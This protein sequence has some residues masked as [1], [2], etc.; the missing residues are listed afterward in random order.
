[1]CLLGSL[2][3]KKTK[4]QKI[5]ELGEDGAAAGGTNKPQT[6]K[7]APLKKGKSKAK[8]AVPPANKV[9]P[10][11]STQALDVTKS[12]QSDIST[13]TNDSNNN[14]N[15]PKIQELQKTAEI[16]KKAA[17]EMIDPSDLI[18]TQQISVNTAEKAMAGLSKVLHWLNNLCQMLLHD[19]GIKWRTIVDYRKWLAK[20]IQAQMNV[21]FDSLFFFEQKTEG[22]REREKKKTQSV[23]SVS[24]IFFVAFL[25]KN[26]HL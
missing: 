9:P 17:I 14:K 10:V 3:N 20:Y 12:V 18:Q 2:K 8:I 1:M 16:T 15:N 26:T 23:F 13:I 24:T 21:M 22:E 7:K 4:K 19:D 5:D 11:S 25:K 6:K